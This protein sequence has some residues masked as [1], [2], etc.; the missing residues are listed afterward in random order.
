[1]RLRHVKNADNIIENSS[2]VIKNSEELFGKWH[3]VFDNNNPIHIEIGMGKG[4]FIINMALKYPNIN[5]IGIEKFDSVMARAVQKLE[6]IEIPNLKLIR[7][8]AENINKVFSKEI[9]T[10][11]LNF[12]D[13]WPK[14]RHERRRLTSFEYLE[15]YDK[16]FKNK[17]HII[18]KTDNRELFCFSIKSFNNYGYYINDLTFDLQPENYPDNVETEYEMRYKQR[19]N[20]IYRIDVEK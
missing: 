12:S 19:E 20:P 16:I 1:M 5:F 15:R 17:A 3:K 4:M 11:Y 13:P 14:K 7:M 6:N 9:D 8:D 2:Y 18:Q 10:I